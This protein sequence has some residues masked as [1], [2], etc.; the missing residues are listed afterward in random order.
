MALGRRLQERQQEMWITAA[1]LPKS[2][3]HVFYRKL[4]ELLAKTGFDRFVEQLCG[5]YYHAAQGRPGIPAG[6]YFR[7]LLVGYFEGIGS[8]RGIAWRCADSLSLRSFLGVPLTEDTPDH[9]SLT[10][11]RDRLPLEVHTEVFRFVLQAAAEHGLLKGKT[12]A[13][14]ATTLE[15]NAAMK[16]IVRRDT[17]EDWN[18]YLKRLMI[19]QGVIEP[20]AEPTA[21]ELRRFDKGR[22]NKRVSNDEWVSETD[23]DSRIA[24]MKDGRT[25]LAYKAENVIDLETELVLAAEIYPANRADT[26][27]LIESVSEAQVH[28]NEAGLEVEIEEVVAD[29]GYHAT[30]TLEEADDVGTRTYIPEPQYAHGRTWKDKSANSRKAVSNNRRRTKTAKGKRLQRQ[31]SERVERSFAHICETGGARRTWLCGFDKVR[32]R[33]LISAMA[34]NLGLLMRAL[35][36]MGTARSLQGAG[37]D[38]AGAGGAAAFVYRAWLAI[39]NAKSHCLAGWLFRKRPNARNPHLANSLAL[40]A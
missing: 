11:V 1:E 28:L 33:Y 22:K 27:T 6:T 18:E 39:L 29:K 30:E 14:D 19:E 38:L 20:D 37:E 36:G 9:S 2:E 10:R 32:K 3:G 31:R 13:V 5:P 25:H 35:F 17:G 24:K 8:Q 21:E 34:R 16:S 40:T 12:V 15:A 26:D 4:N 7:M 23:A